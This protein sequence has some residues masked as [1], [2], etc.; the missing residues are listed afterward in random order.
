[1][2]F[3]KNI[4]LV[5]VFHVWE[6]WSGISWQLTW[7]QQPFCVVCVSAFSTRLTHKMWQ[8]YKM[9]IT[10]CVCGLIQNHWDH[11]S[12]HLTWSGNCILAASYMSWRQIFQHAD[13]GKNVRGFKYPVWVNILSTSQSRGLPP[14]YIAFPTLRLST[15]QEQE[16]CNAST[17]MRFVWARP[18]SFYFPFHLVVFHS[19][20]AVT[21]S[22]SLCLLVQ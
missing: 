19:L 10:Q 18:A 7:M 8:M 21:F 6:I 17:V 9:Y 11:S 15:E 12:Y 14:F 20:L 4:S 2:S 22:L 16:T 13:K 3:T 1:M 5:C